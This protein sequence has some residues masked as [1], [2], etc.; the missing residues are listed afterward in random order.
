M[1]EA[2]VTVTVGTGELTAT[3]S[4]GNP[5]TWSVSVPGDAAYIEESSVDVTVNATKTGYT[6]AGAVERTLTVDLSAPTPP[7]Y[8]A[9]GSLKVGV[10]IARM[11]ASGGTGIDEYGATGLPP[12]LSIDTASG[13]ID[14]TPAA[15]SAAAA[16]ATVTVRD[17]AGNTDTVQI[18]FPTVAKGD[19]ALS[20]F[21]YSPATVTFGDVAPGVAEPTGFKT[22]VGYSTASAAVC[23]V[24]AVSGAL[25]IVGI[26]DCV[27]IATAEATDDYNQATAT[28]TVTVQ[29]AGVLVLNVNPIAVGETINIAEHRDGFAYRRQHRFGGRGIGHRHRRHRGVDGDLLHGQSGHLV[30]ERAGECRLHRGVQRGCDGQRHQ[31]RLHRRRCG[32]THP[33]G[34]SER[35]DAAGVHRPGFA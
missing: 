2:S 10:A 34:G 1:G 15:A 12:G 17:N 14:G 11:T 7:A 23:E 19:Q 25:R 33:H 9:P 26:G 3:S 35:A 24:D 4:T 32:G 21:A 8:T 20:G 6:A 28:V 31:D 30:G 16:T 27:V 5:A 29:A 18:Q 13:A 22:P